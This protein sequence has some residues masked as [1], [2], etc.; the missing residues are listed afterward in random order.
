MTRNHTYSNITLFYTNISKKR[1]YT[2]QHGVYLEQFGASGGPFE[3]VVTPLNMHYA[4][5]DLSRVLEYFEIA[6]GLR[7]TPAIFV[8]KKKTT[9]KP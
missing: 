2:S 5:I 1:H 9:K 4:A 6:P 3:Q 8:A 7:K